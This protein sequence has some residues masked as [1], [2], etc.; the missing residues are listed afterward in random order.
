MNC[1]GWRVKRNNTVSPPPPH[2]TVCLEGA[3]LTVFVC[4]EDVSSVSLTIG[5]IKPDSVPHQCSLREDAYK[6]RLRQNQQ[7]L[8][9]VYHCHRSV[10]ND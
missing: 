6:N 1:G 3:A 9:N 7:F 4:H 8:L 10:I 2:S 5:Y